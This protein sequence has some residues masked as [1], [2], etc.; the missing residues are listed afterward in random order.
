MEKETNSINGDGWKEYGRLVMNELKRL[1]NEQKETKQE[2]RE[3][4]DSIKREVAKIQE[5]SGNV[6]NL[7]KWKSN[8]D[9]V[10][11]PT[12]MKEVKDEV[13]KQKNNWSGVHTV[14]Y[15]I[16]TLINIGILAYSMIFA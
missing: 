5:Q 13:Y 4:L 15:F 16:L 6:S 8:V 11:S 12:Q 14:I 1:D 9:E 3:E 10:M 2:V 7:E